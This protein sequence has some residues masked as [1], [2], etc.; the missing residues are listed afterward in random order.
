MLAAPLFTRRSESHHVRLNSVV[1]ASPC[2]ARGL[3]CS[4]L[5]PRQ[6]AD[7]TD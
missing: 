1:S 6:K 7:E 4:Q 2:T 5:G 3:R